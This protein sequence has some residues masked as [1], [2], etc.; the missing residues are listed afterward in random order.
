MKKELPNT[1]LHSIFH[2]NVIVPDRFNADVISRL[3]IVIGRTILMRRIYSTAAVAF[4]L[5]AV[6]L[7][8]RLLIMESSTT[9]FSSFIAL[10]FT[11]SASMLTNWRDFAWTLLESIPAFGLAAV[12]GA[13]A[14]C[15]GFLRWAG[16]SFGINTL[17]R[18]QLAF[19]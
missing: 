7:A 17:G 11:D 13:T 15:I 6:V 2:Q 9:G 4:S 10:A 14:V 18:S 19:N 3:K 8:S 12:L 1:A 16:K 5:I